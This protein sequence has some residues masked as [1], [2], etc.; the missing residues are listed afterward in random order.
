MTTERK[1]LAI[2]AAYLALGLCIAALA[3]FTE[4]TQLLLTKANE[5]RF[6]SYQL[7][8]ELKQS[9][10]DLTRLART[11]VVTGEPRYE[12]AY[13]DVL[14]VR[15]GKKARADGTT[16]SLRE[17]MERAG[18]T[19][20]E[21]AELKKAEDNSNALVTTETIAMNAVKGFY[22]DGNGNYTKQA[23]PDAELARRI[24]HD[25][26]YHENAALIMAPIHVFET[27]LD[28][29]TRSEV[30]KHAQR[31]D[32]LFWSTVATIPVILMLGVGGVWMIKFR[33]ARPLNTVIANLHG[34]AN[35]IGNAIEQIAAAGASLANGATTQAASLEETSASLEEM[36]GMTKR[37]AEHAQAANALTKQTRASAETGAG[38]MQ[39]MTT[40]MDA[41]KAAS[42]NIAKIIKTIDEIAFQTNIL[43]LNAAVEAARAGEAG[44]GFAVVAEEVRNLAQRSAEAAKE[45][46]A[47]IEDSIQK[48]ERGVAISAKV[49][50]SLGEIVTKARKVDELVAEIASASLEQSQGITQLN[51]AV[52]Q[53]DRVTQAN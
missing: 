34:T 16:L 37:N 12:E 13:W 9:S 18:F 50:D 7:A 35:T 43:A 20:E 2:N 45:T 27:M 21:F 29:R 40:A 22:D 4:R 24:M 51:T 10:E 41:I 8:N 5:N 32:L 36:S 17:L 46:A 38:D 14:A 53:M 48:S 33:I 26:K 11:F 19:A 28:S 31:R 23:A 15:N 25:E 42:D 44:M 52:T 3:I 49:A 1:L 39:E 47:R 30:E 6:V